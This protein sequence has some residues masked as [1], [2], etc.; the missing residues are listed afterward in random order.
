MR[1]YWCSSSAA[2][3]TANGAAIYRLSDTAS[4]TLDNVVSKSR[5]QLEFCSPRCCVTFQQSIWANGLF[6]EHS[7]WKSQKMSHLTLRAKRASYVYILNVQKLIKNVFLN[8]WRLRRPRKFETLKKNQ[9]LYSFSFYLYE[10]YFWLKF[11]LVTKFLCKN[12]WLL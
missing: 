3:E 7:V 12:T 6:K 11:H 8:N 9:N 5:L 4:Q 10:I 1:C 2:F